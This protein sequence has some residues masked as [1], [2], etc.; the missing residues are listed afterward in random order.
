MQ[1]ILMAQVYARDMAAAARRHFHAAE[2]LVAT[3]RKDVAGYLFG[4]AAECALKQMMI[5]SGMRELSNEKRREDPFHAHFEDL[6]TLL[7]DNISGLRSKELREYASSSSFMQ[8][9]A[10]A[11][12]YSHGKDIRPEWVERWHRDAKK[13]LDA[14]NS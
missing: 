7:L 4:V 5:D 13:I 14:M 6:K 2:F 11:M 1:R 8:H 12:R 10:I 9:W 3:E